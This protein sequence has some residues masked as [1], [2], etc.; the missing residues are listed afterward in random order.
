MGLAA[1]NFRPSL[2]QAQR[3]KS[4]ISINGGKQIQKET[5]VLTASA[6]AAWMGGEY[7]SAATL[8]MQRWKLGEVSG[9]AWAFSGQDIT[10]AI[11][12]IIKRVVKDR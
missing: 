7:R 11:I 2:F 10:C 6:I 9:D 1:P 5:R 8:L 4:A 3:A 12:I